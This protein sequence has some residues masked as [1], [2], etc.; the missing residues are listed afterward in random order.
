MAD[1]L[2]SGTEHVSS[3]TTEQESC[4]T[5]N[6][7]DRGLFLRQT[8]SFI[9]RRTRQSPYR[10]E[11]A[12]PSLKRYKNGLIVPLSNGPDYIPNQSANTPK[13]NRP[14][15]AASVLPPDVEASLT[16]LLAAAKSFSTVMTSYDIND[17]TRIREVSA[18]MKNIRLDNPSNSALYK[19]NMGTTRDL[20]LSNLYPTNPECQLGSNSNVNAF[21]LLRSSSKYQTNSKGQAELET[22]QYEINQSMEKCKTD[23]KTLVEPINNTETESRH[24]PAINFSLTSLSSTGTSDLSRLERKGTLLLSDRA[25][26]IILGRRDFSLA[27]K[28][29]AVELDTASMECQLL[30][31][32]LKTQTKMGSIKIHEVITPRRALDDI[33]L[34]KLYGVSLFDLNVMR[35]PDMTEIIECKDVDSMFA[36]ILSTQHIESLRS[37]LEKAGFS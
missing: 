2:N 10:P 33:D 26:T 21:N 8:R 4:T 17:L 25:P 30:V 7:H 35:T 16:C 1:Y 27:R 28:L 32:T 18:S 11:T 19:R 9:D 12:K 29:V 20:S 14:I 34:P 3:N 23:F 31:Y 37:V 5:G 6:A 24:F 15:S 36:I 13:S 22:L